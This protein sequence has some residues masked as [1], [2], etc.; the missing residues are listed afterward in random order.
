MGNIFKTENRKPSHKK[1][2]GTGETTSIFVGTGF[3][4]AAPLARGGVVGRVRAR[5]GGNLKGGTA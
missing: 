3:V 1:K 4:V 2:G 5:P